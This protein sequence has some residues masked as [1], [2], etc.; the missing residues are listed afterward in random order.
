MKKE[1]MGYIAYEVTDHLDL[2]AAGSGTTVVLTVTHPVR[3]TCHTSLEGDDRK[4]LVK[5]LQQFGETK[6]FEKPP[7]WHVDRGFGSEWTG[8]LGWTVETA[9]ELLREGDEIVYFPTKQAAQRAA[10]ALNAAED[11][12]E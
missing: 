8:L 9:E 1:K 5:A 10:D 6:T 2:E 7:K 11:G 4:K 12:D 3:G